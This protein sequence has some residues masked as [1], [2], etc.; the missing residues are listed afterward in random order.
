MWL[1]SWDIALSGRD[2]LFELWHFDTILRVKYLRETTFIYWDWL[3]NTDRIIR[4]PRCHML[5]TW[6]LRWVHYI[7]RVLW[8]TLTLYIIKVH[9][10]LTAL[11]VIDCVLLHDHIYKRKSYSRYQLLPFIFPELF[12]MF[13]YGGWLLELLAFLGFFY[14]STF[15]GSLTC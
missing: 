12:I 1:H 11:I 2:G 9:Y 15:F 5:S 7:R 6:C 3:W 10:Y 14:S 4:G 8:G 13:C